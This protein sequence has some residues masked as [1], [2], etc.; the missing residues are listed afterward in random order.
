[1]MVMMVMMI[2]L[3]IYIYIYDDDGEDDYEDDNDDNVE[4]TSSIFASSNFLK[5]FAGFHCENNFLLF[6]SLV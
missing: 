3:M 6:T 2:M 5:A 1:M 4:V